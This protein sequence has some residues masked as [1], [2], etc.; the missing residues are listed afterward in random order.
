MTIN[1]FQTGSGHRILSLMIAHLHCL[2]ISPITGPYWKNFKRQSGSFV[3]LPLW[4][5][6]PKYVQWKEYKCWCSFPYYWFLKLSDDLQFQLWHVNGVEVI[7]PIF[8]PR[9][10]MKPKVNNIP[11]THQIFEVTRQTTNVTCIIGIP[12]EGNRIEEKKYLK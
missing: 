7:T 8:I 10:K 9:K 11:W 2:K 6:T 3:N 5:S 1:I 4:P 12:T